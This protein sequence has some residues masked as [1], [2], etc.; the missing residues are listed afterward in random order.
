MHGQQNIKIF[1][2]V[3]PKRLWIC[4]DKW[5]GSC[6]PVLRRM[7]AAFIFKVPPKRPL[8]KTTVIFTIVLKRARAFGPMPSQ[9]NPSH[10]LTSLEKGG[11]RQNTTEFY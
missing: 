11:L 3:F 2:A 4:S 8:S 7:S 6:V 5:F 10:V 9:M 1:T